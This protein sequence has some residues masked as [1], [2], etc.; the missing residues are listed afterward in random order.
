ML[1]MYSES[2]YYEL[3]ESDRDIELEHLSLLE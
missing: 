1:S 2:E 3:R